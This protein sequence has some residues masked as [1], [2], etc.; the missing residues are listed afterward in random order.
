[1]REKNTFG[2]RSKILS[3]DMPK[4]KFFLV[5]EGT[6]TEPEYFSALEK[7]K[8]QVGIFPLIE[9]IEI[10]RTFGEDNWANPKQLL[11]RVLLKLEE[12]KTGVKT[13]TTLID[14][15]EDCFKNNEYLQKR[16]KLIKDFRILL[17]NYIE[18][19]LNKSLNDTIEN[20]ESD[21][22]K[23]KSY[24]EKNRPRMVALITKNLD[25][26]FLEQEITYDKDID[27]I[28]LI[29]DR[30]KKS[31]FENQ[32]D[33]VEKTCNDNN[34]KLYLSNPCFEFWLALHFDD[35]LKYKEADIS[36]DAKIKKDLLTFLKN[37]LG[38][39]KKEKYDAYTLIDK[40]DTAIANE[41]M[42]CED[43][44]KLKHILGS[45]VG[46]LIEELRRKR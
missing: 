17:K 2:E 42:F 7:S 22:A 39:F 21:V 32:Y 4:I 44:S 46:K 12:Q 8:V 37:Q 3:S 18:K 33:Y 20:I 13:Y 29:V 34:I 23:I 36:D 35:V 15:I 31:F 30:D 11:D 43:I 40:I 26:A 45:N 38:S 19:D 25:E 27:T 24:F 41:K 28:C 10:E 6:H 14:A 1:M 16:K 5:M 9:I